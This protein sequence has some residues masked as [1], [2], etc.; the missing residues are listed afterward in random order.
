MKKKKYGDATKEHAINLRE[1]SGFSYDEIAKETGLKPGYIRKLVHEKNAAK[2]TAKQEKVT[3]ETPLVTQECNEVT[4]EVTEEKTAKNAEEQQFLPKKRVTKQG[5]IAQHFSLTDWV[6]YTHLVTTSFAIYNALPG[7]PG[8]AMAFIY[9]LLLLD[10]LLNVKRAELPIS[11]GIAANRVMWMEVI[12]GVANAQ[13]INAY[14][15]QNLDKLP[16]QVYRGTKLIETRNEAMEI[17]YKAEWV[18]G[19]WVGILALFLAAL[20]VFAVCHAVL[21][22]KQA[23]M[24]LQRKEG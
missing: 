9:A 18:N 23:A 24:E 10:A 12:A 7:V 19:D 4:H 16:F 11:A 20:M 22:A 15:W 8:A 13:M 6:I 1:I 14:L 2:V 21:F 3:T 17:Q 5:F